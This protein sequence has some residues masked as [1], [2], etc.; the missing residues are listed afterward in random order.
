MLVKSVVNF[1]TDSEIKQA[2][3]MLFDKFGNKVTPSFKNC[4]RTNNGKSEK[5]VL[6][7][8]ALIGRI[9]LDI[10]PVFIAANL[11]KL[12]PLDPGNCDVMAHISTG[13]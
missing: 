8:Y 1:Y 5:N 9:P 7:I 3:D 13:K 6:D 4:Q 2:K 12:S 10:C 11:A